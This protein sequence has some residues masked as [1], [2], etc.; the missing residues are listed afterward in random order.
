MQVDVSQL[1]ED[2]WSML[3]KLE[4]QM[5]RELVM[6]YSKKTALQCHRAK[7]ALDA[8]NSV[9]TRFRS[10]LQGT[11][12][13]RSLWMSMKDAADCAISP[14]SLSTEVRER[15][16]TIRNATLESLLE[17]EKNGELLL[18]VVGKNPW[19]VGAVFKTRE[20]LSQLPGSVDAKSK[21]DHD[22]LERV[23]QK[24]Q[25]LVR[26]HAVDAIKEVCK[27]LTGFWDRP[28]RD[29]CWLKHVDVLMQLFIT[30][31]VPC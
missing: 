10:L 5:L 30:C 13:G 21:D 1:G 27:E 12:L 4:I 18:T 28:L 2:G 26:S 31:H 11:V 8:R 29:P 25:D 6:D 24:L 17:H 23:C 14:S 22:T 15:A 20:A 7:L 9:S 19:L 3:V 16:N